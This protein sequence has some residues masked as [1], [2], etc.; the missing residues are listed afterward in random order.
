MCNPSVLLHVSF[1]SPRRRRKVFILESLRYLSIAPQK[2]FATGRISD[3]P[4]TFSSTPRRRDSLG[5]PLTGSLGSIVERINRTSI[6]TTN[7]NG[8]LDR[9]PDSISQTSCTLLRWI[10]TLERRSARL[11]RP[12][13]WSANRLDHYPPS[14]TTRLTQLS[15]DHAQ[16][17]DT[18]ADGCVNEHRRLLGKQELSKVDKLCHIFENC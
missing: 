15:L 4:P 10:C 9:L 8:N 16:G 5:L 2:T 11:G 1:H 3:S 17:F 6:S 18:F 14:R 7:D 13:T 12:G